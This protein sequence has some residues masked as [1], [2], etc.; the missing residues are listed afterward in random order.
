MSAPPGGFMEHHSKI[1]LSVVDL[2][3]V[4]Y[5]VDV[6]SRNRMPVAPQGAKAGAVCKWYA[7]LKQ[8]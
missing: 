8:N 4:A 6:P 3:H 5:L 1:L 2:F 7:L